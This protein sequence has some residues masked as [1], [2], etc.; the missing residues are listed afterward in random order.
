MI[1]W[2]HVG[3]FLSIFKLKVSY[4]L[5]QNYFYR[6]RKRRETLLR[7]CC[8]TWG[9][10]LE[11]FP[12]KFIILAAKSSGSRSETPSNT[13]PIKPRPINHLSTPSACMNMDRI[14]PIF[15]SRP[16]ILFPWSTI[17]FCL[18]SLHSVIIIFFP[19]SFSC[20]RD[21]I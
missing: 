12:T 17:L 15:L 6:E 20:R 21:P 9:S 16:F 3:M 1:Y 8:K 11:E 4:I 10:N 13:A 19:L 5:K 18:L 14:D 7:L 2:S